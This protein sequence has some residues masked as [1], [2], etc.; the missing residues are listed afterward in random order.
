MAAGRD[1]KAAI[2][3]KLRF[4]SSRAGVDAAQLA[5]TQQPRNEI[6]LPRLGLD[7]CEELEP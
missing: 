2:C 5:V 7:L 1:V 6:D 4:S 3:H